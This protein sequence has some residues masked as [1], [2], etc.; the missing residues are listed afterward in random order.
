M[1]RSV[2][3]FL[4]FSLNLSAK[5]HTDD[6]RLLFVEAG[7]SIEGKK[8]FFLQAQTYNE[9]DAVS[10]A[11]KGMSIAMYAKVTSSIP[12]KLDC[13]HKG[14]AL[15]EGAINTDIYNPEIRFLRYC[16]Q[17]ETPS[18]LGYKSNLE[19]DLWRII[20]GLKAKMF[21]PKDQFWQIALNY[22]YNNKYADDNQKRE[23][24]PFIG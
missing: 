24:Q 4:A 9:N 8:K 21:N 11:Y 19:E 14:K 1:M 5:A 20:G 6:M 2:L 10:K 18:I 12:E 23:L 13:F 17:A 3:F 16:M 7:K 22:L 15:L